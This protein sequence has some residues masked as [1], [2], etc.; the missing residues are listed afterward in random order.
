MWATPPLAL[1][2]AE[3]RPDFEPVVSGPRR[4]KRA[5]SIAGSLRGGATAPK[6][7]GGRTRSR[8][9]CKGKDLDSDE[10]RADPALDEMRLNQWLDADLVLDDGVELDG[11]KLR[12]QQALDELRLD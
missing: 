4:T 2:G 5:S 10:Q 11:C 7:H 12:A 6:H 1:I 8:R 3:E 9:S